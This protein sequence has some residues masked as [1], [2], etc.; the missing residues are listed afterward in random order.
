[1]NDEV[2]IQVGQALANLGDLAE[3]ALPALVRAL[4]DPKLYDPA[5]RVVGPEHVNRSPALVA[6]VE[7]EEKAVP[8]LIESFGKRDEAA[9]RAAFAFPAFGRRA[10]PPLL[11]ALT[12]KDH[13]TRQ[14][15]AIALDQVVQL[16]GLPADAVDKLEARLDDPVEEVRVA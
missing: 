6:L 9:A 7:L 2:R 12:D 4:G 11:R 10:L 3:P 15:A 1:E 13:R 8:L 16:R 5:Y 14:Y